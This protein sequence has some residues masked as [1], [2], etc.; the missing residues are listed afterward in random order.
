MM[1]KY[2]KLFTILFLSLI[3][4]IS[5]SQNN[6][7]FAN[8]LFEKGEYYRAISE[9]Y[10]SLF[11]NNITRQDSNLCILQIARSNYLGENYN[12]AIFWINS[13]ENNSFLIKETSIGLN[14]YS[15]LSYLKLGFPKSSILAFSKNSNDEK[16]LLM[17]G[18]SNLYLYNWDKANNIFNSLKISKHLN[19]SS[20]A[21]ELSL[22]TTKATKLS[23]RN[24]ILAGVLSGFLPGSGY[25]YTKHYQ[26]AFSSLLLNTILIGTSYE[27]QRKGFKFAGGTT[28]LL[29]FGWY[30]GN[31][32][33]SYKSAIRYNDTIR[34]NY[35]NQE[36]SKYEYYFK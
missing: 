22:I 31:I 3:C 15:G 17:I 28:F 29:A 5:Y 27:L 18:V 1:S 24:P 19:I 26:T 11:S 12:E 34:Q 30:M 32:L 36:L 21:N 10:R 2:L 35:L 20:D 4:S 16:S 8:H 14:Y 33:G 13:I 25:A 23:H 6:I 9:Y 7:Q